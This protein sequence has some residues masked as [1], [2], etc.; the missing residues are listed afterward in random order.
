MRETLCGFNNSPDG[1]SLGSTMLVTHGPTLYVDIG[2]DPSYNAKTSVRPVSG[3]SKVRAL[4][5]SGA[6]ESCIDSMLAAEL[7]LPIVNRAFISGVGG[8]H[9]VNVYLAQVYINGLQIT[10]YGRF[11]GVHLAAGGQ[12][13]VAL[14]GRS[15]L[16]HCIMEYNGITGTVKISMPNH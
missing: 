1:T 14:I 12:A 11:L 9:E 3:I 15:F 10:Q 16:R 5:D 8:K 7:G 6:Q 13:H 2:F 4:V